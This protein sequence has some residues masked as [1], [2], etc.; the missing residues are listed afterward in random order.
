MMSYEGW[1]KGRRRLEVHGGHIRRT[2]V[3]FIFK[4][5]SQIDVIP[6][7]DSRVMV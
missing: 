7:T 5:F 4:E 1:N 6:K 3:V 2:R